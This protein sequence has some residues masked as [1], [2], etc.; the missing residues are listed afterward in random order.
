MENNPRETFASEEK[1]K[2]FASFVSILDWLFLTTTR[3]TEI[4]LNVNQELTI[5][6]KQSSMYIIGKVQSGLR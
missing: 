5:Y 2:D 6:L 1:K 4:C 3:Y